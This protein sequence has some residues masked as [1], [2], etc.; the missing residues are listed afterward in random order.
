MSKIKI[1]T[2]SCCDLTREQIEELGITVL[3]L[4]IT[5]N[6]E[7][8]NETFDKTTD[9]FYEMLLKSNEPA[10]HAAINPTTFLEAYNKAIDEGYTDIIR[11]PVKINTKFCIHKPFRCSASRIMTIHRFPRRFIPLHN[12]CPPFYSFHHV[13]GI[14]SLSIIQV[15]SMAKNFAHTSKT[16]LAS[17]RIQSASFP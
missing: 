15:S 1:I 12:K 5:I 3:P 10:K 16:F 9:E 2:D 6:G 11:S 13:S 8:F 4:Q 17:Q 14:S 7:T